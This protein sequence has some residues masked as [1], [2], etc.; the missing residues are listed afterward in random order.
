VKII[1]GDAQNGCFIFCPTIKTY[2]FACAFIPIG[3]IFSNDKG[4]CQNGV[5]QLKLPAAMKSFGYGNAL[6][7]VRVYAFR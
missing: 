1:E 2:F 4:F 5:V 6:S 7:T 3:N